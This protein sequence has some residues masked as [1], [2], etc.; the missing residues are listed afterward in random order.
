MSS[1]QLMEK[2]DPGA[3]AKEQQEV[4]APGKPLLSGGI[5]YLLH[6]LLPWLLS[7]SL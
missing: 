6:R 7:P 1:R 5:C 2:G 3:S 4:S